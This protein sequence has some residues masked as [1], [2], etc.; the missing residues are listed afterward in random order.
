MFAKRYYGIRYYGPRYFG[1]GN[2][3]AAAVRKRR[4]PA[5][6]IARG[7]GAMMWILGMVYGPV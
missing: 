4:H 1:N 6:F 7:M 2:S 3:T 5:V